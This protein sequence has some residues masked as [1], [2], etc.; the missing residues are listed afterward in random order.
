MRPQSIS[1]KSKESPAATLGMHHHFVLTSQQLLHTRQ[2][3]R[4]ARMG[5]HTGRTGHHTGRMGHQTGRTAERKQLDRNW[6][7]TVHTERPG[8]RRVV[9]LGRPNRMDLP[10]NVCFAW[11]LA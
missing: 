10:G 5:Q 2:L 7:H 3:P 4:K 1:S 6:Q 8:R 11:L 9:A